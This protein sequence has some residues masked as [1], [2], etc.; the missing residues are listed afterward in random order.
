[1]GRLSCEREAPAR[2]ARRPSHL[3]VGRTLSPCDAPVTVNAAGGATGTGPAQGSSEA[4]CR[5]DDRQTFVLRDSR[6]GLSDPRAHQRGVVV[7]LDRMQ[8]QGLLLVLLRCSDL[9]QQFVVGAGWRRLDRPF[10][11]VAA[12]QVDAAVAPVPGA[13]GPN[14]GRP[15]VFAGS[16][17]RSLWLRLTR[18]HRRPERR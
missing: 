1:M 4:A 10:K 14:V 12:R 9:P 5:G 6:R 16:G 8:G 17:S 2:P 18:C 13:T 7:N 15:Q 11:R 3:D